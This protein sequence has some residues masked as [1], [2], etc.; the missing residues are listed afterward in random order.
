M[1]HRAPN[2]TTIKSRPD[3]RL[4]LTYCVTAFA[5]AVEDEHRLLA[6]ALVTLF[7]YPNLPPELLQGAVAGQEIRTFAAQADGVMQ[8]PAEFWGSMDN[9]LKPSIDYKVTL[10][11]DL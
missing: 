1:A 5:N 7:Q 11:I 10:K 2:N 8:S 3:V 9:D 6:R 4:D